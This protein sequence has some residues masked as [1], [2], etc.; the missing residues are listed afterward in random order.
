MKLKINSAFKKIAKAW[1]SLPGL[2]C[3]NNSKIKLCQKT[4]NGGKVN[5]AII[6]KKAN[7]PGKFLERNLIFLLAFIFI[8]CLAN[9][10]TILF[11]INIFL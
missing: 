1:Q 4:R 7:S 10:I 8:I 6:V 2:L 9:L 11:L 3:K 5:Q